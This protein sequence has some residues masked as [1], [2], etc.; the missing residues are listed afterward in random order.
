MKV[1]SKTI[2]ILVISFIFASCSA[3]GSG[4][5][6]DGGNG[7]GSPY[8]DDANCGGPAV[9]QSPNDSDNTFRSLAVHP[10]D[11]NTIMI[12][13]EGNGIFKSTDGG[14]SWS[15]VNQGLYYENLS[16][17]CAYPEVYQITY[18]AGD[19]TKL[20]AATT[21]GPGS[22]YDGFFYSTD[23]GDSWSRSVE[24]LQNYALLS[25]AQ[26]PSNTSILYVGT[27]NGLSTGTDPTDNSG[28][29]MYKSTD[30]G[31]NWTGI[32]LPVDDN[33]VAYI[34]VDPTDANTVYCTGT[35]RDETDY[36][37]T[38]HLGVAKSGDAGVSWSRIN[39]GLAT[40]GG[41]SITMDPNNSSTLYA[42][43]WS[44]Q[45]AQSYRS[46]DGGGS[47]SAFPTG[48]S[49]PSNISN[50]TAS[51]HDSNTIIGF[52]T[53]KI[54]TSTDG[55]FTWSEAMDFSNTNV[56]LKK[57]VFTSEANIVYISGDQLKVYKSTDGGATFSAVSG[58]IQTLIGH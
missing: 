16:G 22:D 53:Q 45:G 31:L 50:L 46:Q 11:P 2:A 42:T 35:A 43:T 41:A 47:W 32:T 7:G 13:N 15:R 10:A 23:G 44:D 4:N 14:A 37:S 48:L 33:G 27:D 9:G 18:D 8:P 38:N 58:D 19:P 5:G 25:I 1:F 39:S 54:Y 20:Y 24:G 30:G 56:I 36:S 51:P 6:S 3:G 29:N 40:L 49:A 26:D 34:A 57:I 28:P 12:G 52:T 21:T 55:G 17:Y